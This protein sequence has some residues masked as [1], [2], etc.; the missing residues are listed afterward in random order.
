MSNG[1]SPRSPLDDASQRR[2]LFEGAWLAVAAAGQGD[3]EQACAVGQVAVARTRTVR[4]Q[5][6]NAVL[7]VLA[8]QLRRRRRNEHVEAFLPT[9]R[10]ALAGRVEPA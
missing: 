1:C 6:S 5:R 7:G 10:T 8:Q 4:S 9:L 2:A 3:L